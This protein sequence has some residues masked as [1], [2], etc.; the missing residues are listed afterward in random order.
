MRLMAKEMLFGSWPV[1]LGIANFLVRRSIGMGR[2]AIIEVKD[3][4]E[5]NLLPIERRLGDQ[6]VEAA[7]PRLDDEPDPHEGNKVFCCYDAAYAEAVAEVSVGIGVV[8]SCQVVEDPL[9][10]SE[11]A[12]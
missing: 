2:S 11:S 7:Y 10:E 8:E 12:H 9:D 4:I 6:L 5:W 1:S 3:A